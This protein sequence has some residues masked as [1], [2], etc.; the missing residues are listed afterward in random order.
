[1]WKRSIVDIRLDSK[2]GMKLKGFQKTG[3]LHKCGEATL[4]VCESPFAKIVNPLMPGGNKK[5]TLT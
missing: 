5:V 1:M 2:S 3:G 4:L